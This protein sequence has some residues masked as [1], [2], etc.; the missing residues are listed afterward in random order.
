MTETIPV[1]HESKQERKQ[2]VLRAIESA[3]AE[4]GGDYAA[5]IRLAR[6]IVD[7]EL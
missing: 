6:T 4:H 5:G 1:E 7:E 3:A 2:R